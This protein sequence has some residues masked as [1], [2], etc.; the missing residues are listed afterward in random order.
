M[1]SAFTYA[2]VPSQ[3]GKVVLV[4]GCN[5]GLGLSLVKDL[6]DS[7]KIA[8]ENQ[9]AVIIMACRDKAKTEAAIEACPWLKEKYNGGGQLKFLHLDL[10]DLSSVRAAAAEAAQMVDKI[11][12]LCLNAGIFPQKQSETK[13]GFELTFGVCHVGHFLLTKLL[14][15]LVL[16][17]DSAS[18]ARVVPVSSVG[19]TWTK[20]GLQMDDL[21]WKERKYDGF[22]AYFQAKLANVLFSRE[23]ARRC[24]TFGKTISNGNGDGIKANVTTVSL[25][26]GYGRSGLYRDVSFIVKLLTPLISETCDKLSINTVR[27]CCDPGN[28]DDTVGPLPSGCYT[29]PKRMNFYGP[30]IVAEVSKFGQDWETAKTLWEKTEELI[31]EKFEIS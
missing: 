30:P 17:S 15:P 11:D 31:G 2:D 3:A 14:W 22:E 28:L 18:G 20:K 27:A 12:I 10:A 7:K 29:T 21:N 24:G 25:S 26:P 4:T 23:L 5:Q 6:F 1:P 8:A 13:D 9:P 19:H 16:K